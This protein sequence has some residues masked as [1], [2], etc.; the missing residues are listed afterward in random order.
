MDWSLNA[1]FWEANFLISI[2]IILF[3][4]QNEVHVFADLQ[5]KIMP[6]NVFQYLVKYNKWNTKI[7]IKAKEETWFSNFIFF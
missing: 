7:S 5:I 4:F 3:Y 2:Y 6:D 1:L